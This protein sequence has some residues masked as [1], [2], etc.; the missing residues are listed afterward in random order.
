[1]PVQADRR[2]DLAANLDLT[3][4][5]VNLD[6]E[7]WY[8]GLL[9]TIEDQI[10]LD[11]N[12]ISWWSAHQHLG[13][14]QRLTLFFQEVLL[15]E[16]PAPQRIVTFGIRPTYPAESFGYIER[17]ETDKGYD[18]VTGFE[19]ATGTKVAVIQKVACESDWV[20]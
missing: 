8:L 4:I 1:M 13:M 19:K 9:A 2:P 6:A 5:G 14:T 18:W 20:P 12:P 11:T 3:A 17:G 10:E 16:V 7:Q 15:Q